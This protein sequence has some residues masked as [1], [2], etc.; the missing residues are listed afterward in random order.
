M[1]DVLWPLGKVVIVRKKLERRAKRALTGSGSGSYK[2]VTTRAAALLAT[3]RC[4]LEFPRRARL[5][6]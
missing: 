5:S 6:V 1:L 3:E 2:R 4:A